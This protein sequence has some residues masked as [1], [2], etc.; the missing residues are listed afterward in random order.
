M[1]PL[2]TPGHSLTLTAAPINVMGPVKQERG[3]LFLL[4]WTPAPLHRGTKRFTYHVGSSKSEHILQLITV[5]S[6]HVIILNRS[7]FNSHTC[8]RMKKCYYCF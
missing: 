8:G 5:I 1:A 6:S 4:D 7:D 3:V 2:R